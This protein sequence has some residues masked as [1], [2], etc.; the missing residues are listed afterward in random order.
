VGTGLASGIE[1]QSAE[2]SAVFICDGELITEAHY[3]FDE[4][5]ALE[6]VSSQT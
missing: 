2:F 3:F 1:T 6:F 5:E 4:D